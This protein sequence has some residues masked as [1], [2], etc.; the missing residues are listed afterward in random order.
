MSPASRAINA[1][2]TT[3]IDTAVPHADPHQLVS[4]L[5]DGALTAIADAKLKLSRAD[6]PGRGQAIS[7]AISII[8]L[9]LR[10]SLDHEKGGEIAMHLEDL[11]QYIC[12]RLLHANLK[13]DVEGLDEAANLLRQLDSGWK[14]IARTK[15][16]LAAASV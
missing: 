7:K 1:Y 14:G 8:D 4:M 10:A 16:E 9:G 12:S 15:P 13:S 6:I 2:V 3:E 11:Y 5:F